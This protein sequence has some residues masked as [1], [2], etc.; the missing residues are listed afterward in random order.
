MGEARHQRA[1]SG[2]LLL[3]SGERQCRVLGECDSAC[4]AS[5]H[6]VL[7]FPTATVASVAGTF[8]EL[9]TCKQ[10]LRARI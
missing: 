8:H 10:V 7:S 6:S 3:M 2:T 1:L 4:V 5:R 9:F